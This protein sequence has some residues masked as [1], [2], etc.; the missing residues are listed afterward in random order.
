MPL[1][2]PIIIANSEVY[3]IIGTL[4]CAVAVDNLKDQNRN[5]TVLERICGFFVNGKNLT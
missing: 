1:K 3:D 5:R 4:C 2:L